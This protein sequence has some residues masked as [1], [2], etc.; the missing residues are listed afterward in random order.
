MSENVDFSQRYADSEDDAYLE[1]AERM[2]R[3]M[4]RHSAFKYSGQFAD[5]EKRRE[6]VEGLAEQLRGGN[7]NSRKPAKPEPQEKPFSSD[8]FWNSDEPGQIMPKKL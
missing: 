1:Q 5:P 3:A 2:T 7:G 8:E 6:F 4:E